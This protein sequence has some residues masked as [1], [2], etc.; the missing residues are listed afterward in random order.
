MSLIT[1]QLILQ[2]KSDRDDALHRLSVGD[3][4]Q[5][6]RDLL[7][8][9]TKRLKK[10][11]ND[12]EAEK[13][14]AQAARKAAQEKA[15]QKSMKAA[16][17]GAP[18]AEYPQRPDL[19][20]GLTVACADCDG[21]FTFTGKD[22]VFFQK[23]GWTQPTRCADCREA[24]KSAKPAGKELDCGVCKAKFFFSDAKARIFEEKSWA[25]PKRC[26]DCLRVKKQ[27]ASVKGDPQNA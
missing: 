3:D 12:L 19:P 4:T 24:K 8:V 27:G 14:K 13:A 9:A 22:Q 18:R 7:A 21:F 2:A 23:Q 15:D 5:K 11:E 25:E 6:V 20:P 17:G 1:Q 26:R 10:L 16:G